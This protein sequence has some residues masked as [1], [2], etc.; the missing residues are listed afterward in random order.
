MMMDPN[1]IQ[2]QVENMQYQ[3]SKRPST[4]A[5]K[6][7]SG[8]AHDNSDATLKMNSTLQAVKDKDNS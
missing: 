5:K 2:G 1:D 3:F 7:S 6:V 4:A 8:R